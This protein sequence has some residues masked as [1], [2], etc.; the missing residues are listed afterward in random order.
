MSVKTTPAIQREE[1][2]GLSPF[3]PV[4]NIALLWS[5]L[6]AAKK[7]PAFAEGVVAPLPCSMLNVGGKGW[8]TIACVQGGRFFRRH[9]NQARRVFVNF[10]ASL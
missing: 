4:F 7:T 6:E 2:I 5:V 10:H 8:V 3:A 1:N 9:R